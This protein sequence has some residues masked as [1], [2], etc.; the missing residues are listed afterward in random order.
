MN[1]EL[2]EAQKE[3]LHIQYLD[4]MRIAAFFSIVLLH[5]SAQNWYKINI[6]S[7][8]WKVFTV[9]NSFS[10]WGV[11]VFTMIS[12]ALWLSIEKPIKTIYSKNIFRIA[13]AFIL[14]SFIYASIA[15]TANRNSMSFLRDLIQ[16]HDHMWF[17]FM[18]V[19]LYMITPILKK[20]CE[21]LE[22]LRYY[23]LLSLLFAVL[24]PQ[25]IALINLVSPQYAMFLDEVLEKM[26]F[27]FP[28]GYSG[29]FI[30]G[31][32]LSITDL[33]KVQMKL[34]WICGIIGFLSTALLTI[35]ISSAKGFASEFFLNP[36]SLNVLLESVFMFCVFKKAFSG[37]QKTDDNHYS[38]K[39]SSY[40]FGAYLVHELILEG[41]DDYMNICT[42]SFNP[43]IS[44]FVLSVI[45]FL[46]SLAISALL[47]CIPWVKRHFV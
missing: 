13:K 5:V 19:G 31:Y 36:F 17:L 45:L 2:S 44:V 16:G 10:R 28:L 6:V 12:G 40:C 22:L 18:I 23:L 46:L 32:Y 33:S 27:Y 38:S 21:S 37:S 20:I 9:Y 26:A 29:Y 25:I 43:I 11:P 41:M 3:N 8:E 39:I 30:L 1:K 4:F 14:W 34:I 24:L 35:A 47:H 7:L 42:L 15:F